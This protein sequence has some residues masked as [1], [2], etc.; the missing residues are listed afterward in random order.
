[1]NAEEF[2]IWIRTERTHIQH[3]NKSPEALSNALLERLR[4]DLNTWDQSVSAVV[5]AWR[6]FEAKQSQESGIKK[7]YTRQ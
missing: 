6:Q 7:N 4:K 5:Y 3:N 2:D 1:M